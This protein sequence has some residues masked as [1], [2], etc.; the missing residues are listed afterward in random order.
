MGE[1]TKKHWPQP[2]T[3]RKFHGGDGLLRSSLQAIVWKQVK[4]KTGSC[5][6]RIKTWRQNDHLSCFSQKWGCSWDIGLIMLEGKSQANQDNFVKFQVN[7]M[8][9]VSQDQH[10]KKEYIL[11]SKIHY[12]LWIFLFQKWGVGGWMCM[13]ISK[14]LEDNSF[15]VFFSTLLKYFCA[16]TYSENKQGPCFPKWAHLVRQALCGS[17]V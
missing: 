10:F 6:C 12:I 5:R 8:C 15:H 7:C 17:S 1:E 2:G 14:I 9:L 11:H 4:A 13:C 3:I 16:T